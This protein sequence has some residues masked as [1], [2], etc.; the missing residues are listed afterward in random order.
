MLS[1]D[2]VPGMQQNIQKQNWEVTS[3]LGF[4]SLFMTAVNTFLS[5]HTPILNETKMGD[6]L[7]SV[8]YTYKK[9][10]AKL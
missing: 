9:T 10:L 5:L 4:Q 8:N 1:S 7:I 6:E 3:T 2:F